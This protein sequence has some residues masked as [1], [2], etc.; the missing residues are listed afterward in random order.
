MSIIREFTLYLHAGITTPEV[1]HANQYSQGETWIFK[2]LQDDGSVYVPSTGA[3]I[4]VKADGH[5]IAGLTG[6]VLGDG[7]VSITTTQQLTAAAG[8]ATCELTI[9]GG[10]NGSA[11]FVIRVEKKPTDDAILSES[12]LSIIQQGLNSVTPAAINESVSNYLEE[13]LTDP[14]IDPSLSISNAAA[15]AK[16]TGDKITELKTEV[17]LLFSETTTHELLTETTPLGTYGNSVTNNYLWI[18]KDNPIPRGSFGNVGVLTSNIGGTY[19]FC[20]LKKNSETN[21]TIIDDYTGNSNSV[22]VDT[23]TVFAENSDVYIGLY[24]TDG[25]LVFSSANTGNND[26]IARAEYQTFIS[27]GGTAEVT[28]MTAML[29]FGYSLVVSTPNTGDIAYPVCIVDKN[30]H[31]D[32]TTIQEAIDNTEDNSTI[33]I[34]PGTY[35]EQVKMWGKNRHLV[36]LSKENTIIASTSRYYNN[37]PL[38]ANIGSVTN[39]TF[40]AGYGLTPIDDDTSSTSY[41]IHVEY[42]NSTPYEFIVENCNVISN[43]APAIGMGVRYNQ[44]VKVKNSYL[45]TKAKNMYSSVY[46][47]YFNV[48]GIFVHNDA[49]GSN[50]GTDG[51][52]EVSNTELKGVL[53]GITIQSQNN[54]NTLTCRFANDMLWSTQNGKN[55]AVT[56]R[57]PATAGH[58]AGSDVLLDS[59]SFGNNIDTLNA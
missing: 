24:S 49:S 9:D 39:L 41:A 29:N 55:N 43:V 42:A 11:N 14:P 20:T 3:L 23:Y 54:G 36:G 17:D 21:Y 33:L 6:T 53:T 56:I 58:L 15:D 25:S 40:I 34:M 46:Q 35:F 31:G 19:H 57:T 44:T 45:E 30:R 26:G 51:R 10:T 47:N 8:D 38:Q 16:V 22:K 4:G 7:R 52:L 12:D 59:M 18:M 50:L 2:L 13:N 28:V 27:G 1:I 5:A 48:G 37:E 32:Y